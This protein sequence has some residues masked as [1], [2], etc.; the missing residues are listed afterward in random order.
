MPT[1][2]LV[3]GGIALSAFSPLPISPYLRV[4]SIQISITPNT[5][6]PMSR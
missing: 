4:F 6:P 3:V 5:I 2:K 1:A